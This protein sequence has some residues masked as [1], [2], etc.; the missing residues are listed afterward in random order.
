MSSIQ[1]FSLFDI[2]EYNNI[3]E[4]VFTETFSESFYGQYI[5]KWSPYCLSL[6]S[7]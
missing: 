6:K 7:I 2:L 1:R 4:D 5:S 3:N